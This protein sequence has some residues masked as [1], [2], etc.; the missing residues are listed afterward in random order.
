MKN[1]EMREEIIIIAAMLAFGIDAICMALQIQTL[2][3]WV[4][5]LVYM[6]VFVWFS[7]SSIKT[8]IQHRKE[9][10]RLRI[11]TSRKEAAE[12]FVEDYAKFVSEVHK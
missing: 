2:P 5:R 11:Q 3:Y 12:R 1:K 8:D 6:P 7:Y 4:L 9:L 10:F